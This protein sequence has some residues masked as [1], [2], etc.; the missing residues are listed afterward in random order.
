MSASAPFPAAPAAW[1]DNTTPFPTAS[2]KG[3]RVAVFAQVMA[4]VY[5]LR[6]SFS[7]LVAGFLSQ[8][9]QCALTQPVPG[10]TKPVCLLVHSFAVTQLLLGWCLPWQSMMPSFPAQTMGVPAMCPQGH[11]PAE[12]RKRHT[13][14][15]TPVALQ[16]YL[17]T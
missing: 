6:H 1:L 5:L 13:G 15:F 12:N 8:L 11:L 14:Y 2:V 4:V 9:F 16:K 17:R 10:R 7:R 3:M